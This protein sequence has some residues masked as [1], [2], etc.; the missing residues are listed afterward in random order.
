MKLSLDGVVKDVTVERA[1]NGFTVAV[2]GRAFSVGDIGVAFG[3]LA[4]LVDH[5]SYVAR[6]SSGP[7]GLLVSL[8]GRTYTLAR[9]DVDADRPGGAGAH[10]GDGR[11]EAPMPGSIVAVNV[12]VGD[13]VT[14]GQPVVVLESMKMHN[15]I[16]SPTDGVVRRVNCEVG[17]Q[18]AFGR[19]LVEIGSE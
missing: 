11:L 12:A 10:G 16:T 9:D 5:R 18:V 13:R 4:F 17:E 3:T 2:D 14:A 19:V 15:E 6:V 7:A 8:G 1:A